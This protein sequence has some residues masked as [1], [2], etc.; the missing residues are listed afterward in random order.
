MKIF[1]ICHQCRWHRWQTLSCEYLREFSK[2]FETTLMVYSGAW[3]KL[4]HGKK[5]KS[6]ISWH[7]PFKL[8]VGSA[9]GS[10][11]F[12]IWCQSGS[13]SGSGCASTW[14]FGWGSASKRC[15]STTLLMGAVICAVIEAGKSGPGTDRMPWQGLLSCELL[16]NIVTEFKRPSSI[17]AGGRMLHGSCNCKPI[18]WLCLSPPSPP[19]RLQLAT[20]SVCYQVP[21]PPTPPVKVK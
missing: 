16:A 12:W 14:K 6:K 1:C 20:Q 7:C 15:R 2:K 3:G 9:W 8:E 13:E 17:K 5:Q 19:S 18:L 11:S 10:A 4:I 21:P